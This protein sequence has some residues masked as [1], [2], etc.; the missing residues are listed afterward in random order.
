MQHTENCITLQRE[1]ARLQYTATRK[2]KV[3]VQHTVNS[4]VKQPAPHG[5]LVLRDLS[6]S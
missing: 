3:A 6:K 5:K 2:A 4:K 1:Q